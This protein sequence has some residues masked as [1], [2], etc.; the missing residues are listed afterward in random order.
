MRPFNPL[1]WLAA[2]ALLLAAIAVWPPHALDIA[3]SSP[4]FNG[5]SFPLNRAGYMV[6]LHHSLRAFP[7]AVAAFGLFSLGKALYQ[8]RSFTSERVRR[9]AYLLVAMLV[10][11]MLIKFLRNTTGVYCPKATEVFGGAAALLAPRFSFLPQPGHCWPSGF[12]GTGFCLFALFFALRDRY[13]RAGRRAFL[14]A[15]LLGVLCSVVQVI[16]GEHFFNDTLATALVDWLVCLTLYLLFHVRQCLHVK[17][18][19][20]AVVLKWRFSAKEPGLAPSVA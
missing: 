19:G 13:P 20:Q 12:A 10:C 14:F 5:V 8:E 9:W 18:F 6:T 3:L 1:L 4:W 15:L 7:I 16:R 2:P 11:V 17:V